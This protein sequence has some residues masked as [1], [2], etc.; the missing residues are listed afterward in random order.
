MSAGKAYLC[1]L[2][3]GLLVASLL[4]LCAWGLWWSP[5]ARQAGNDQDRYAEKQEQAE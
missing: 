4:W 5:A 2:A 3:I 1:G